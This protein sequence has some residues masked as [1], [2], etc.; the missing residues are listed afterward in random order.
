[1]CLKRPLPRWLPVG[2]LALVAVGLMCCQSAPPLPLDQVVL[3]SPPVIQTE[4]RPWDRAEKI[5]AA[6]PGTRFFVG[7]GD[8]MLPLYPSG[9]IVVLQRLSWE[10][11]AAGMIVVYGVDPENPYHLVCHVLAEKADSQSWVVQ[12]LNN[13]EPDFMRVTRDNY[14][15]TVIAALRRREG[16]P[17]PPTVPA[18]LARSPDAYCMIR[19]HVGGKTFPHDVP[20]ALRGGNQPRADK[21]G[22]ELRAIAA[23]LRPVAH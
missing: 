7:H 10:R 13:R 14:V 4:E 18:M 9:T 17:V 21:A 6:V 23:L 16:E 8:S 20:P 2:A 1:M 19:C 11:L 22:I 15:G 5:V 3:F 12:G